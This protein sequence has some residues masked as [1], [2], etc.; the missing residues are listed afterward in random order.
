MKDFSLFNK[1]LKLNWLKRFY[2][3]SGA[4]RQLIPKS[5]LANVGG[6]KLFACNYDIDRINLKSQLP[7]F[8]REIIA[9]WQDLIASNPK[10]RHEVL[11]QILWNN[12]FITL[13]GKSVYFFQW[14]QSGMKSLHTS[15]VAHQ[16]GAYPGF[17]GMK[18]LGVFLLPPGWDLQSIAGLPPAFRRY[19][20]IHLGGDRHGGSKVTCP[21]TQHN[22]PS[23]DS[24]PDHSLRSRAQ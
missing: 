2:S 17:H 20:F 18:R 15:Q 4:P 19:P 3:N 6:L 24:N 23:Q 14:H 9:L 1:A 8:Y 12:K 10:N 21:R 13:K 7:E 11:E 16:A 22:V 5:L